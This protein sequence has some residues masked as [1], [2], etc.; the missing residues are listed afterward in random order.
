MQTKTRIHRRGAQGTK[1]RVAYQE[2]NKTGWWKTGRVTHMIY[3]QWRVFKSLTCKRKEESGN[4]W[5]W[6]WGL[7]SDRKWSGTGEQS[8]YKWGGRD[9]GKRAG[10]W[11]EWKSTEVTKQAKMREWLGMQN[12]DVTRNLD[13]EKHPL[14]V[15]QQLVNHSFTFLGASH[16]FDNIFLTD[17]LLMFIMSKQSMDVWHKHNLFCVTHIQYSWFTYLHVYNSF[18]SCNFPPSENFSITTPVSPHDNQSDKLKHSTAPSQHLHHWRLLGK[19]SYH[20]YLFSFGLIKPWLWSHMMLEPFIGQSRDTCH[21]EIFLVKV[22]QSLIFFFK[23]N[24]TQNL[25]KTPPLDDGFNI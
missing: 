3:G 18:Q 22:N 8:W 24:L 13:T 15:L 4:R 5:M 20:L 21:P 2:N 11:G 23:W 1:G 7:N 12:T 6:H 19:A 10:K 16:V 25:S 17:F 9:W 14:C